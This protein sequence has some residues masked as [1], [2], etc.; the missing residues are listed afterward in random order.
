M[1]D[2]ALLQRAEALELAN[3]RLRRMLD[4]RGSTAGLRHQV[5]NTLAMVRDVV[6]RSAETSDTVEDYAAHLEGRLDAVFRIQNTI[7][8]CLLGGIGLHALVADEFLA[9]ALSPGARLTIDGPEVVL[10]PAAASAV[11][12]ALH[13]LATNAL[14]FGALAAPEGRIAVNWSVAP[15][16]DG[17]PWLTLAWNESGVRGMR[18]SPVRRG[19][20]SEVIERALPYQFG[21]EGV[22]DFT[23]RGLRCQLRLPMAPRV[24]SLQQVPDTD[25]LDDEPEKT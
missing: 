19:F 13:E 25:P 4:R 15:S 24:T 21:G 16:D 5:R 11:A 7:A 18:P 14:K 23:S 1:S 10:Q 20:G 17:P 3:A 2:D 22:L 12:L 6:R 8:T 9:H